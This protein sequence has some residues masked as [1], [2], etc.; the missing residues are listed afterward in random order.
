MKPPVFVLK[1]IYIHGGL[2]ESLKQCVK[3][4]SRP[5][6]EVSPRK[7][8]VQKRP[9]IN[10]GYPTVCVFQLVHINVARWQHSIRA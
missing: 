8:G 7:R 9:Y 3:A 4:Y 1:G 10:R 5:L 6:G 2:K